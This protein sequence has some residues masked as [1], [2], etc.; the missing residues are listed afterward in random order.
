MQIT[1][2]A[3]RLAEA[4]KDLEKLTRRAN[5]AGGAAPVTYS[6][7]PIREEERSYQEWDGS[8]SNMSVPV[9]D[10]TFEGCAPQ[11]DGYQFLARIT[12]DREIGNIVQTAPGVEDG[13][14]DP[15]WRTADST[16]DHCN[17]KRSRNDTFVL[18]NIKT[19]AQIN[20]GRSCLRDF[21]GIDSPERVLAKFAY[22][23]MVR[24]LSEECGRYNWYV[25][26]LPALACAS[27]I[28]RM[29]GWCPNSRADEFTSSTAQLVNSVM[30]GDYEEAKRLRKEVLENRKPEDL[31]TAR[32]A[33]EWIRNEMPVRSDYEDNLKK[34]CSAD[35][36]SN[37][38]YFGTMISGLP[39]YFRHIE[40]K[41]A[42]T[43][44]IMSDR[45]S[46]W[47]GKENERL[48]ALSVQYLESR[49]LCDTDYGVLKLHK[50]K[51]EDGNI[52]TWKTCNRV[53][54]PTNSHVKLDGTVKKHDE[55]NEIQQT[56][57]TRVKIKEVVKHED[58]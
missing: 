1:I 6:I 28:I 14:V 23:K 33:L 34:I 44:R 45:Q 43:R 30:N 58:A 29:R 48:R 13:I 2:L 57:L 38:R 53:D 21:T 52:F 25:S 50:F 39:A 40:R 35:G 31:E 20:V 15:K 4:R 46:K 11:V 36:V 8:W 24:D 32:A 12:H 27:I 42:Y 51:D 10:I 41:L 37:Y 19:G 55:W 3:E 18:Q 5:R 26:I 16:C 49:T 7:S 54:A 47:Q 22:S 9:I 17:R 56:L